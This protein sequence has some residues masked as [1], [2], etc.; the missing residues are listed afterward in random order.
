MYNVTRGAQEPSASRSAHELDSVG[1][2]DSGYLA[3]KFS[4]SDSE[5]GSSWSD[6]EAGSI[7]ELGAGCASKWTTFKTA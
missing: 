3:T 7:T 1:T 6:S 5:A 4:W 2:I